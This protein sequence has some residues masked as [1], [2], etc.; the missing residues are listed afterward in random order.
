[1]IVYFAKEDHDEQPHVGYYASK[2][3]AT[4]ALKTAKKI[5]FNHEQQ[6]LEKRIEDSIYNEW[7]DDDVI[8]SMK[9]KLGG[10]PPKIQLGEIIKIEING[11]DNFIKLLNNTINEG[12]EASGGWE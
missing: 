7:S 9:S 12:A 11:K 1:M 3:E 2:I 6:E 5:R 10:R 8:E 4:N